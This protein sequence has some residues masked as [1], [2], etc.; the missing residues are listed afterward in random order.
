MIVVSRNL[1]SGE[2]TP[3]L[4]NLCKKLLPTLIKVYMGTSAA[5]RSSSLCEQA[6]K[7]Y[8]VDGIF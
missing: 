1:E 7:S 4:T 5:Q 3:I 6:K 8:I 2:R